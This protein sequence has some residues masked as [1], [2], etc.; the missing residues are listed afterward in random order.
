MLRLPR[1]GSVGGFGLK[2]VI[3]KMAND[4]AEGGGGAKSII[5]LKSE[6]NDFLTIR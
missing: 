6:I 3:G 1:S 5:L 2:L 4:G